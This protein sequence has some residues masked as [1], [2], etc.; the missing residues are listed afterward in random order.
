MAS[1][2]T[3][4]IVRPLL[5][6][7]FLAGVTLFILSVSGG[8]LQA[9]VFDGAGLLGGLGLAQGG[10]AGSGIRPDMDLLPVVVAVVNAVLPY[11]AVAALVAFITAGFFFILGFGSD[12]TIQ[13][14]KKILIWSA[15]GLVV[16]LFAFVLTQFVINIASA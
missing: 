11:A 10:I 3:H 4:G 15:A 14:A 6:T 12:T 5:A 13:R 1:S 8:V 2:R 9:S 7:L 16:I